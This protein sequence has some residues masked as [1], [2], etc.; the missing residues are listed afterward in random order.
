M[1]LIS[2]LFLQAVTQLAGHFSEFLDVQRARLARV[3]VQYAQHALPLHARLFLHK[4]LLY[5]LP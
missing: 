3:H 5:P 1:S 4:L 2:P